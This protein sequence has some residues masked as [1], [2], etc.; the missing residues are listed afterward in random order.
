MNKV[1]ERVKRGDFGVKT[2]AVSRLKVSYFAQ[3]GCLTE[4][5]EQ[6]FFDQEAAVDELVKGDFRDKTL[7]DNE[8]F[9][10]Y[11]GEQTRQKP[12][13][14]APKSGEKKNFHFGN[15]GVKK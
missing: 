10:I 13:Q 1:K 2:Q 4:G 5:H 9:E 15:F 11:K 14:N 7:T 12:P 8:L 3:K 6:A